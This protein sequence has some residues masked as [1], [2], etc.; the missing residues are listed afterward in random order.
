MPVK[1]SK[2]K[3]N[4][5]KAFKGS[6]KK[7]SSKKRRSSEGKLSA[8]QRKEIKDAVSTLPSLLFEHVQQQDIPKESGGERDD[9]NTAPPNHIPSA[10]ERDAIGKK[11]AI[12]WVTIAIMM[13]VLLS[14]W[15][16]NMKTLVYDIKRNPSIEGE[17]FDTA[18]D[19]FSTILESIKTQDLEQAQVEEA[20]ASEEEQRNEKILDALRSAL[21]TTVA[22]STTSTSS[23]TTTTATTT[24]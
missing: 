19:D 16:L 21:P 10:Q 14:V 5:E 2:S 3:K 6:S 11:K 4:S 1:P 12:I 22:S 8:K 15:F 23:T 17:L 20:F 9:R 18:K 24:P 13:A 7:S